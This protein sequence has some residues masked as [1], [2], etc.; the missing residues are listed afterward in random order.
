MNKTPH[1][2][3]KIPV[4]K[5]KRPLERRSLLPSQSWDPILVAGDG[6]GGGF[7]GLGGRAAVVIGRSDADGLIGVGE[8][9]RNGF[10]DVGD[11]ADLDYRLLGL[12]EHE[13]FVD[14]A[15]TG[16]LLKS[17]LATD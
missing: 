5:C 4:P 16:L 12:L 13:F 11:R 17:R 15:N 3:S 2:C 7:L 14:G 1:L 9:C 6:F 8:V 10:G